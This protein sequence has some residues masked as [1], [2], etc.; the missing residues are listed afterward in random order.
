MKK[1]F[2]ILCTL[3]WLASCQQ[4]EPLLEPEKVNGPEF[5]AQIEAFGSDTKTAL[6]YGNSVVWSAGDQLAIFQGE[7]VADKYQVKSDRVGTTS[8]VFEI[9]ANGVGTPAATF[10]I[11]VA[12]YPYAEAQVCAP[13]TENG[14][15]VSYRITG[16]TVPSVQTYTTDSFA[17]G[18]FP[19]AAMS[20]GLDNHTLNFKNLCGVLKLQLKGT[21][22]V[23]TIELKGNGNEKLSGEATVEVY[24][25]TVPAIL[26][27]D[28]ASSVV[29][30][31]CG[32]GIQLYNDVATDFY[33]AVPPTAFENGFV[34][35]VIDIMG[36]KDEIKTSKANPVRR[37]YI[38]TMPVV[39]VDTAFPE[40]DE[41]VLS[42][43]SI[44]CIGNSITQGVG[45]EGNPYPTQL[46]TRLNATVKNLGVSGTSLCE[47][48]ARTCNIGKLTE[49]N[50][51]GQDIVTIL[52]GIN[53]W[54]AARDNATDGK[55]YHLGDE[56]STET[57]CIYGAMRMWCEK[58]QE[59]KNTESCAD[60]KFYFM[61]PIITSWNSS[62]T[63]IRDWDQSKTNV[64][65]F[66]LR[67]LC[68]AIID[69]AE[70]YDIPVID[71]NL[72]SGIYYN[73]PTDENVS[74]YGGDGVHINGAGHTLVTDA[75]IRALAGER[76][77]MF[78]PCIEMGAIAKAGV[79][80]AN[81]YGRQYYRT[82]KYIEPL[83][84]TIGISSSCD[85]EVRVY[86]YD[87]D[88]AL[89]DYIDYS[90]VSATGVNKV[91]VGDDCLYVKMLFRKN[92]GLTEFDKPQIALSNVGKTEYF[93]ICPADKDYQTLIIP[94]DVVMESDP[95]GVNIM[96]DYGLL[97]FPKTYSNMGE[98]TRLIIYCHGAGLNYDKN[99]TSFSGLDADYFLAEGF[100]VMDMDGNPY[101][102]SNTHGYIP[103]A[104]QSY[105]A[106][107]NWVVNNYNIKTDGVF[108]AGRSMGG[109]MVFELLQTAIP[110]I[111]GCPCVP[112][113]NTLWWWN[114]M[115]STRKSFCASKID[116]K[117]TAPAWGNS[118]TLSDEELQYLFD[119][120]DVL[121]DC[122]PFW[123]GIENLPEKDVLFS[124]GR[125]SAGT[126]YDQ[127]ED[128]LYSSLS[129][130]VKAPVKLFTCYEDTTVPYGRNAQ[131]MYNMLKNA[132][133]ECEL[134][135]VHT[136]AASPHRYEL[137][138]SNAY[139]DVTTIAGETMQA[140]WVYVEM[141]N[142]WRK[143]ENAGQA[144]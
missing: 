17:D 30:L 139:I 84:G 36:A 78:S 16:L 35:T 65:G 144:F 136:D 1:L 102:N 28:D 104:S 129:F 142:F 48:G 126:A 76:G 19:M 107:Y 68:H 99:T 27:S 20:D 143:H 118:K 116:F 13:V 94:V 51:A 87:E 105:V 66:T 40:I 54:A 100:A 45:A 9:V 71:L 75:I 70:S 96:D 93:N 52:M 135:L 123:R 83:S 61:T 21:V 112:V 67:E 124:V 34:V 38:H 108:L 81:Y 119:N 92:S 101:D 73:S 140:P 14:A 33:I 89:I 37:S 46:A 132:G 44:A 128:E 130:K 32:D 82:A 72:C 117:G 86:R 125:T 41:S 137:D 138:D 49:A 60:T 133:V 106:A 15:A 113:C 22:K 29:T 4:V 103:A 43:L 122:S 3:L 141:L 88:F 39:A 2:T 58:I 55:Y 53:D 134:S 80:A 131:L 109:G 110:V 25:D 47:G 5:S 77:E 23:K 85:C 12:V 63:K 31:D 7:S 69:V 114:Y 115:N 98:P 24:P 91:T 59:L 64:H 57:N 95:E 121:L 26:M 6:A 56:N 62:V 8:G 50:C 79:L 10:K 111:A 120:F 90:A 97:K 11:N 18:S 74:L 127:A 42:G